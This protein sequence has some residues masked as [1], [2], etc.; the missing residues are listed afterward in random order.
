MSQFFQIG[1]RVLWNPATGVAQV[2]LRAAESFA[3]LTD[4]PTGLGPM[5]ADECEI[6]IDVFSA[7]VD[8]LIDRYTRSN[9]VILRS[10]M[11]GFTAT[12]IV[13]VTRG[14]GHLPALQ[15]SDNPDIASLKELSRH[16]DRAMVT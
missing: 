3:A 10:L 2:F 15:S 9:H 12:A 4:L 14:G 5:D 11:Q 8:T 16:H 7:F 6:D 1:E 13:L